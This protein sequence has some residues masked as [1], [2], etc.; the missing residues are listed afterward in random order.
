MH[1]G[2]IFVSTVN[3]WSPQYIAI[4][5]GIVGSLTPQDQDYLARNLFAF[6]K[7]DYRRV[8]QLHIDSG[9]VPAETKLNE[10]EAAIRTVCEPIF[11]KN[12]IGINKN[13]FSDKAGWQGFVNCSPS[14]SMLRRGL[15]GWPSK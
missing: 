12:R 6:F 2:N 9:W 15:R 5:C 13:G 11:E 4:D 7:R 1:P 10:F 14:S 8:A 3:P